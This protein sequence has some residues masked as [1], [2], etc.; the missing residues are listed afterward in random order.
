MK[1]LLKPQILLCIAAL[2]PVV[3]SGAVLG[4][5]V[6]EL[7]GGMFGRV[8]M[9]AIVFGNMLMFGYLLEKAFE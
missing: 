7:V 5:H 8:V 1:E 3:I 9:L 4:A 6:G 2:L